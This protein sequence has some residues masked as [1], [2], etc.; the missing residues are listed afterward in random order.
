MKHLLSILLICSIG[1][2]QEL[3][4]EGDLNV[5]GN[6][7][8]QTIDS[9][10]QV[11]QD[12][13]SQLSVLQGNVQSRSYTINVSDGDI[14]NLISLTG[15][16]LDWYKIDIV[17]VTDAPGVPIVSVTSSNG[18]GEV[19]VRMNSNSVPYYYQGDNSKII[20][21]SEYTDLLIGLYGDY[22]ATITLLVT[23]PFPESDTQL[24]KTGLQSKDK[25]IVK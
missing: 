3:T 20:T 18:S 8:N 22:S 16:T 23:A 14:I 21:T 9:L 17:N 19:K 25:E 24:R 11:I 13:Q 4:V 10:L 6:I 1:F 15:Q 7:Q 12:L 5:T 2:T